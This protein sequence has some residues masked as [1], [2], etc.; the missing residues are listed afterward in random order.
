MPATS[1][2]A[3]QPRRTVVFFDIYRGWRRSVP[4]STRLYLSRDG[5]LIPQTLEQ[6][7]RGPNLDH[8]LMSFDLKNDGIPILR[9]TR[10]SVG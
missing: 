8:L 9:P 3:N 7:L 4:D 10:M 6:I 5:E 1:R 2:D